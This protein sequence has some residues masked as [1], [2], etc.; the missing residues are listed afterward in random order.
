[1][2]IGAALGAVLIFRVGVSGALA[3]A[4]ALLL[5]NAMVG[6]RLSS[7]TAAWTAAK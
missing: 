7:S 2:F 4:V 5:I 6:Y 3:V 1:M